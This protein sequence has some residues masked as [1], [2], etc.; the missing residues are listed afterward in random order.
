L[1]SNGQFNSVQDG[2]RWSPASCINPARLRCS[3]STLGCSAS[4]PKR[5]SNRPHRFI[6]FLEGNW[7]CSAFQI[8]R[9][10]PAVNRHPPIDSPCGRSGPNYETK[11]IFSAELSIADLTRAMDVALRDVHGR[12]NLR[13][14][15]AAAMKVREAIGEHG[16]KTYG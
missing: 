13:G 9:I 14:S 3:G 8:R 16:R 4:M 10:A 7:L 15:E 11:P 2:G 5:A 6:D 1:V 12:A